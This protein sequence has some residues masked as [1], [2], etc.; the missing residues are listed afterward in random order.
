MNDDGIYFTSSRFNIVEGEE[1]QTNSGCFGRELGTWLCDELK[2]RGYHEAELIP[3]DFGWCVMCSRQPFMLWVGCGSLRLDEIMN[4]TIDNPPQI[5]KII[6]T[7]FSV[8]EIPFF[9]L[10][11]HI[12][13]LLGKIEMEPAR[14]KLQ[15]ELRKILESTSDINFTEDPK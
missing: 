5:E 10:R 13:K 15:K 12:L 9:Y 8:T 11:S 4:S 14:Q 1:D 6:W 7:V 3:E 2:S